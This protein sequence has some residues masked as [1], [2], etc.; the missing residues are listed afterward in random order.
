MRCDSH[1]HVVA[2]ATE[3][4]QIRGRTFLVAPAPLEALERLA[5]PHGVDRFVITQPSF[6]C[7]TP[8]DVVKRLEDALA[9]VLKDPAV[10]RRLGAL[11]ASIP[12][13]DKQA[14]SHMQE[15]VV[16]EIGTWTDILMDHAA[17]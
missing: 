9:V 11:G 6:Y 7:T 16:R 14:G 12:P 4:Q 10:A 1:V 17:Q 2:P 8:D 5:A 3:H 13:V 15:L